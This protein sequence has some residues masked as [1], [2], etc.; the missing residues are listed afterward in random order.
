[1]DCTGLRICNPALPS[2]SQSIIQPVHAS[3]NV[4]EFA[5][6]TEVPLIKNVP[7]IQDFDLNLAGRYTDYSVSGSVQ[8]WKVGFNWNVT[9]EFRF[10]GTT[11]IDIRAPT[12]NDLFQPATLLQNVFNGDLHI[13]IATPAGQPQ[14]YASYTATYSSQGNPNLVPEV[15]RTYTAGFVWTPDFIAA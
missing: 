6:E 1:M 8:T 9:D 7:L 15:S 5:L 11:S 13:P 12:L 10:R 2:Y 3:E 4:W 14:Q